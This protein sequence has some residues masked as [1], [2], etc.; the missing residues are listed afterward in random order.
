MANTLKNILNFFLI[1]LLLFNS[2]GS[3]IYFKLKEKHIELAAKNAI[4]EGRYTFN[5][6]NT[7]A[8]SD[9][10]IAWEEDDEIRVNGTYYD[11]IKTNDGMLYCIADEEESELYNWYA[12]IVEENEE[13]TNDS[14]D[15]QNII[16]KW[17]CQYTNNTVLVSQPVLEVNTVYQK[18]I[19]RLFAGVAHP[20]PRRGLVV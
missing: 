20:P 15:E 5:G 3:L 2:G 14:N 4:K 12:Q 8:V 7:F 16:A 11:I 13:D 10:R 17:Y 19:S 1:G 18:Y 9:T 6:V